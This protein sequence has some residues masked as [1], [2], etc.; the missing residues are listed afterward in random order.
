M[1]LWFT[2]ALTV[3]SLR[4][5]Y[6]DLRS[7]KAKI[8]PNNPLLTF[9]LI[10][11]RIN[12]PNMGRDL[13]FQQRA[14]FDV[15]IDVLSNEY[16]NLRKIQGLP[17]PQAD[18]G[19]EDCLVAMSEDA[20]TENKLLIGCSASYYRYIR[21][22]LDFLMEKVGA[23]IFQV[24]RNLRRLLNTFFDHLLQVFLKLEVEARAADQQLRCL[25]A[26]PR[27]T[28]AYLHS[29]NE[30]I[31]TGFHYLSKFEPPALL[32]YGVPGI[33]KTTLAS[34]LSELLVKQTSIGD[35]A[36][37]RLD[38]LSHEYERSATVLLDLICDKL[39][40]TRSG[41]SSLQ[42]ILGYL[43]FFKD[44]RQ[45]LLIVLDGADNWAQVLQDAWDWLGHCIV[46]V[47]TRQRF[48]LWQ[49]NEIQCLP[50][51]ATETYAFLEF[52][53]RQLSGKKT[54]FSDDFYNS[55]WQKVGGN[56]GAIRQTL[57]LSSVLPPDASL[58]PPELSAFY[59]DI[60]V[61]RPPEVQQ[62]WVLLDLLSLAKPIEYTELVEYNYYINGQ[63]RHTSNQTLDDLIAVG[64][65]EIQ[66]NEHNQYLYSVPVGVRNHLSSEL[67][68]A[69]TT[70]TEKIIASEGL[71][72]I[73]EIAFNILNTPTYTE[74]LWPYLA[75]LIYHAHRFVS[76]NGW[77]TQWLSITDKLSKAKHLVLSHALYFELET[78]IALRWLGFFGQALEKTDYIIMQARREEISL[79]L[80]QA[81]TEKSKLLLYF[82]KYELALAL[83][84]EAFA[85]FSEIG[86]TIEMEECKVVI[87][88]SLSRIDSHQARTWVDKI[89]RRDATVWEVIN[90]L[91][92]NL[93]N[94]QAALLAAQ[95]CVDSQRI[96][97]P[98]YARSLGI[99]A[100]SLLLNGNT[101]EAIQRYEQAINLLQ[102]KQDIVGLAR[103][104]NNFGAALMP[105]D[106]GRAKQ[107]F[108]AALNLHQKLQDA[109]GRDIAEENLQMI[110]RLGY[111]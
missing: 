43:Q 89:D 39:N 97:D 22:D 12:T 31:D 53:Q 72:T 14:V 91:E 79:L 106:M 57:R 73:G 87:L 90:H 83:A 71:N 8:D 82:N 85:I 78:A 46:I 62:F 108:K 61:N 107:Q 13:V 110:D 26:L 9:V 32:L 94:K 41:K 16:A 70:L 25:L 102:R 77:W 81:L 15:L 66:I 5:A 93:G 96:N 19:L 20:A 10:Q 47:T 33:G 30:T 104:Y 37:I 24:P 6:D 99:L 21:Y 95:Q 52:L 3:D 63:N 4:D 40:L 28:L 59:L 18:W 17:Y 100:E 60:W 88:R 55:I 38:Q 54:S 101:S 56:P 29:Q 42:V 76:T 50:L 44:T 2:P 1:V 69:T 36:W 49:G 105:R 27:Q 75:D 35:V 80:G 64:M 98:G 23:A 48:S 11:R 92:I 109:H 103:M 86:A 67:A 45:E 7:A 74:V 34:R 51:S 111:E 68:L 58:A 84:K 65:I